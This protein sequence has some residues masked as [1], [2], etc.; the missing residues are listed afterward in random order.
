MFWLFFTLIIQNWLV[1]L[2]GAGPNKDEKVI[3]SKDDL[4]GK[5]VKRKKKLEMWSYICLRVRALGFLVFSVWYPVML[6]YAAMEVRVSYSLVNLVYKLTHDIKQR[7][8]AKIIH[9]DFHGIAWYFPQF[10]KSPPSFFANS[11]LCLLFPSFLHV[12][13]NGPLFYICLISEHQPLY[14]ALLWKTAFQ[15][16]LVVN[17]RARGISRGA[18]KLART[19]TLN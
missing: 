4:D 5:Q 14:C 17:F 19:P 12:F 9:T 7:Q 16:Y 10:H 13:S 6:C 15:Y 8:A 1:V 11:L 18:R 3:W 2:C